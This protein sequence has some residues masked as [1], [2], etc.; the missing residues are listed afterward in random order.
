VG[1]EERGE[2]VAPRRVDQSRVLGVEVDDLL[3]VEVQDLGD[4]AGVAGEPEDVLEEDGVDVHEDGAAPGS[5]RRRLQE[6]PERVGG[7]HEAVHCERPPL[8]LDHERG[9][10]RAPDAGAGARDVS[11]SGRRWGARAAAAGM[12][13]GVASTAGKGSTPGGKDEPLRAAAG[14]RAGGCRGWRREMAARMWE[15]ETLI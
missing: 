15:E 4:G 14:P 10:R 5:A 9:R 6:T 13:A 11:P 1:E 7:E 2:G 12:W 3:E 8:L